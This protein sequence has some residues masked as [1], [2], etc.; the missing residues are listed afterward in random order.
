MMLSCDG[1]PVTTDELW[2]SMEAAV[3]MVNDDDPDEGELYDDSSWRHACRDPNVHLCLGSVCPLLEANDDGTYYCPVTCICYGQ[4]SSNDPITAKKVSCVD[5]NGVSRV[6]AQT[7]VRG[8]GSYGGK[9]RSNEAS[10]SAA[11][12]LANSI[13]DSSAGHMEVIRAADISAAQ[14]AERRQVSSNLQARPPPATSLAALRNRGCDLERE[15]ADLLQREAE[16]LLDR[17]T[18]TNQ[19]ASNHTVTKHAILSDPSISAKLSRYIR[20]CQSIGSAVTLDAIHNL[21]LN[22]TL[23]QNA[24]AKRSE[25]HVKVK[26]KN[27]DF[28]ELRRLMANLA[29]S[30]WMAAQKTPYALEETRPSE[31]F[32]PF[33]AGIYFFTNRGLELDTHS[34]K[35]TII[36][37]V[38]PIYDALPTARSS[39]RAAPTHRLHLSAHKGV[40]TLCRCINSVD[41][42]DRSE[43]FR[44]AVRVA[45]QLKEQLQ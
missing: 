16:T 14:K 42:G 2:A 39:Q 25:A 17:L 9:K 40:R 37:R 4:R 20:R 38:Q 33:V 30:L 15:D 3:A 24:S 7:A 45:N 34:H 29:V 31:T 5:D 8:G 32:R 26:R 35:L 43:F 21:V 13:D 18:A 44:D 41:I 36:P 28:M 11:E 10:A 1:A 22:G 6:G 27:Q 12:V 19:S 23:A